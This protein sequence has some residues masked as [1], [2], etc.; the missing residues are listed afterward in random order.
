[1]IPAGHNAPERKSGP[2]LR[3]LLLA[4]GLGTRLRPITLHTPKCLVTVAGEPLLG[5]WLQMLEIAGCEA[6]LINTHYLAD[7]VETYL[8][9]RPTSTM[10]VQAVHEPELLGTAG[11]LLANRE[12]FSGATGLLIHADNAMAGDLNQFLAAHQGRSAGCDLTMLTFRTD[13]PRSCGIVVTD[14]QGV[15]TAFHEKVAD[16]PGTCANGALYAFDPAFVDRLTAMSPQP[17]DF[18][19]EVIPALMGRI[20]TWHTELP[21]LDIG[22][23]AALAAAQHLLPAVP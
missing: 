22:T 10:V 17:S 8:R 7:Q 2:P 16:P 6:V 18:S 15:V 14:D 3:A 21:Y 5:R 23:P 19:T 9:K 13:Q 1:M 12:F 4:A 20:Q 11:T